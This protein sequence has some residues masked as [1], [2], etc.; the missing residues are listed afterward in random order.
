MPSWIQ[1]TIWICA[2]IF[3]IYF[4]IDKFIEFDNQNK[5]WGRHDTGYGFDGQIL[6]GA[7]VG[8][9]IKFLK[10]MELHKI[11]D[12]IEEMDDYGDFDNLLEWE[13]HKVQYFYGN[14]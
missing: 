14:E 13:K 7:G 4:I 9:T 2:G 6:V 8:K 1:K 3:F 10:R 12:Y 5:K 11:A